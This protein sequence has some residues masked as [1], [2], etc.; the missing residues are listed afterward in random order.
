M[1]RG[2]LMAVLAAVSYTQVPSINADTT[3]ISASGI[4]SGAFMAVQ[5]HVAFSSQ[6]KGVG[7]VAGGPY[8]CSEGSPL[9]AINTCMNNPSAINTDDLEAYI[10]KESSSGIDDATNLVNS[11]VF[12]FAGTKDTVVNPQSGHHAEDL[13]LKLGADVKTEYSIAAEHSMVTKDYGN[14]CDYKG[15]PYIN[16]CD[17]D[18]AF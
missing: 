6:V 14:A 4:S 7:V 15:S 12:I 9:T 18:T 10:D 17:Y 8:H 1:F 13:Y 3:M 11:K 16:K 5:F 2:V